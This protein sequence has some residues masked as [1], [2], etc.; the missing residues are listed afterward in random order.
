MR[1]TGTSFAGAFLTLALAT[2]AHPAL[3]AQRCGPL[4]IVDSLDLKVLPSG[5]PATIVKIADTPRTMLVDTGGYISGVSQTTAKD[6]NLPQT[7]TLQ[8]T[9]AVNGA[10]TD[11]LARLPTIEIGRRLRQENALYYVLANSSDEFDGILGGEFLKQYDSDFDF[12]AQRLNLFSIDHCPGKG[13]YWQAPTVAVVPFGL[14]QSNH[15]KF[16]ME[17]DGKRLN[18]ILDTGASDTVLNLT[19]AR[20]TFD[21]DVNAPGVEKV[22]EITG[23]YTAN[24]YQRRFKTIS[25]G[26]VTVLNPMLTMLPDMVGGN[27]VVPITGYIRNTDEGLP[28]IIL[29]MNLLSKLHLYIA[30]KERKL[31]I[32]DVGPYPLAPQAP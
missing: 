2:T 30:Y 20:R 11:M 15:I 25:F 8:G 27:T 12:G 13:V 26:G 32:T 4:A 16:R 14:D 28:D 9:R 21:V 22:G 23:G 10:T 6:L 24:Y 18:A 3:A 19:I 7:R 5:R 31:Y 17:L 29:G 1:R